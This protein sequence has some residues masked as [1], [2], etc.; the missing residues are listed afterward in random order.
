MDVQWMAGHSGIPGN[1]AV[2]AEAKS[3]ADSKSSIVS[4]LPKLL[5]G[6]V[7]VSKLATNQH[8]GSKRKIAWKKDWEKSTRH[9]KFKHLDP[10]LPS[11][12][13]MKLI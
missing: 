9:A 5:R 10:S 11:H 13:F 12:N 4:K 1:E 6:G 7:K 8:Q 3:A 2:D